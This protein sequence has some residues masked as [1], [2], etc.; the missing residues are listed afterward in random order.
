[1]VTNYSVRRENS[2]GEIVKDPHSTLNFNPDL[3][4]SDPDSALA[5]LRILLSSDDTD[6]NSNEEGDGDGDD[7]G[8]RHVAG[9]GVYV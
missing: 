9:N 3:H 5:I 6:D 8:D 2:A 7:E 4:L 1:M